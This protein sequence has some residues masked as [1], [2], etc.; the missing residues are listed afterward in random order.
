MPYLIDGH[1]LIPKIPGLMLEDIDDEDQLLD[2]LIKFCQHQGKQAEVFFDNAPPGGV[3]AHNY[4]MVVARFV[5][6]GTTADEAIRG[7][8]ARLGRVARNWTVVSSDQEIQAE[9]RVV[10]AH[11][12]SSEA[13]ALQLLQTMDETR[14]DKSGDGE[15]IMDSNEL[16]GWLELFNTRDGG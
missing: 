5:R 15:T 1:N 10:K 7:R 11:Y 3:R 2:L 6:Q 12:I 8:L 9:A 13:F 16:D 14:K 4:G